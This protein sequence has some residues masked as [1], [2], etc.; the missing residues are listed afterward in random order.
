MELNV[1]EGT[2]GLDPLVSVA[3]VAVHVAVRVGGAAVA[4]EVHDL[5]DGLL[6][7]GKVVPEHG[8]VL[9]VGLGVALL[10]VDEHGEFARVA[11]EEDRSIVEDPVPVTLLSVELHSKSSRVARTVGRAL[12]T[13]DG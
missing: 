12:F 7:G 13:S 9:E 1:V 8:C 11:Q 4:E 5:M 10:G 3:G 2:I 6:V